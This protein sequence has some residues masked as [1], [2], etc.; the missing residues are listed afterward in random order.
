MVDYGWRIEKGNTL[1][2]T[3]WWTQDWQVDKDGARL[4][5]RGNCQKTQ[6]HVSSPSKHLVL[7]VLAFLLRQTVI[8]LLKR[9]MIF[10]PGVTDGPIFERCVSFYNNGVKIKDN[11]VAFTGAMVIPSPRQNLRHVASADSFSREE[12]LSSLIGER[13]YSLEKDIVIEH[14]W[15]GQK[16]R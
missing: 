12:W 2:T 9:V 8:P 14:Q 13:D 1:S 11:F 6:Y 10:R 15:Q 3:N 5:V 4:I 16:E 7:R